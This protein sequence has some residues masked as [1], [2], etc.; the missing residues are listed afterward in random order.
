MAGQ[1]GREEM[2]VF[3]WCLKCASASHRAGSW[4]RGSRFGWSRTRQGLMMVGVGGGVC[5]R[6]VMLYTSLLVQNSLQSKVKETQ[7]QSQIVFPY[8]YFFIIETRYAQWEKSFSNLEVQ[9]TKSTGSNVQISI[10]MYHLLM[11]TLFHVYWKQ[12]K[13]T[14]N[15]YS[16]PTKPGPWMMFL[17]VL[18][19]PFMLIR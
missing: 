2:E 10:W 13:V 14:M 4:G 1:W 15:E 11:V 5:E 3:K 19:L 16:C 18:N 7:C 8:M 12:Y 9:V 6:S 17:W